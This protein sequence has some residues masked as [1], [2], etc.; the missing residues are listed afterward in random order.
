MHN[1][2]FLTKIFVFLAVTI[3]AISTTGCNP[4]DNP[5]PNPG[6]EYSGSMNF[7]WDEDLEASTVSK[8]SSVNMLTATDDFGRTFDPVAGTKTDKNR[9]VGLFYFLWM[10]QHGGQQSD[11]FDITQMLENGYDELWSTTTNSISP[12][13]QYHYW[14]KPLFGY[15]NSADEWVIRKHIEL[16]TLAGVDFLVFDATNAFEYFEVVSVILPIMQEYYDA[17]W[18]VPKFMFYTNSSSADVVKRL[19]EGYTVKDSNKSTLYNEGIYK[20]GYYSD[21]WFAPNGKPMIVAITQNNNGASDQW[22]DSAARLTDETLLNFF[23]IKESQWP[24]T[25]VKNENGFPW[26]EFGETNDAYGDV[27]NVSVAQHNKLPFSDA[28]LSSTLADLMR[29]RGY[30][31]AN[32]ADHSNTAINSGLNIEEQ[33]QYAMAQDDKVTYT[34]LTGWNEWIALKLVGAPGNASYLSGGNYER[35]FFVDTFNR[36]YSR[37][38]EMMEGGYFDNFYL[39]MTRNIRTYKSTA[40]TT[41]VY[42]DY[43]QIDISAGLK[44]WSSVQNVYYDFAGEAIARDSDGISSAVHYTDNSNRNDIEEV[45]VAS[46]ENYVYFLVKCADAIEVDLTGGNWMNLLI[47]VNGSSDSGWNGYQFLVNRSPKNDGRTSV[48]KLSASGSK[49]AY[50]D[51]GIAYIT[52]NGQY[53]QYKIPKSVLGVT[54]NYRI[55]FK[56]AD[57]VTDMTSLADFYTTGDVCPAGRMN[58]AYYGK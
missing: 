55:D 28:A 5:D 53:M 23:E 37:D 25:G 12:T 34:F 52:V 6:D 47:S 31:R 38:I 32:G 22:G 15:Y 56:V 41:A 29:G 4:A 50:T 46:D 3:M 9:Y 11:A 20:N 14:G 1:K 49:I 40:L 13:G 58:Y 8:S 43:T 16:L 2:S 36:E 19:Y 48:E 18:N 27:V 7:T 21:L 24:N 54:D 39:Q 57:N 35:A 51:G 30:T 10:G 17:G 44:Q 45:R 42:S 33:W 26:I